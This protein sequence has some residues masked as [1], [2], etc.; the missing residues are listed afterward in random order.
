MGYMVLEEKLRLKKIKLQKV[1]EE[2]QKQKEKYAKGMKE[3]KGES[4]NANGVSTTATL[5]ITLLEARDL[6]PMDF[7]GSSDPY[8]VFRLDNH[9]STS[10]FKPETLEPVWNEDFSFQVTNLNSELI[11]E[12]YDKDRVGKD[13]FEGSTTIS[14]SQLKHQNKI[15]GWYD[16]VVG[17][18][19]SNNGQIRLRLQLVFSKYKYFQDNFFKVELQMTRL[20]EDINELNRL[21]ELFSKPFGII[22]YGEV[23][24]ILEKKLLERSEDIT[25]YM[26]SSRKSIYASP[27]YG[28]KS[29]FAQKMENVFRGTFSNI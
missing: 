13:D 29:N 5:S 16:L 26:S 7:N 12:V 2:L 11:V 1:D 4:L 10:S 17:E 19:A 9:K 28:S 18:D 27:R 20:Q 22:I 24:P 8:V 21:F 23:L 14:L 25:Q 3:S 15:D 6:K